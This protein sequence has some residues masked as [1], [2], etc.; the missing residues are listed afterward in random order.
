M[1]LNTCSMNECW[2]EQMNDAEKMPCSQDK[3]V[4]ERASR[5]GHKVDVCF[6]LCR[7]MKGPVLRVLRR[8]APSDTSKINWRTKWSKSTSLAGMQPSLGCRKW[9]ASVLTPCWWHMVLYDSRTVLVSNMVSIPP[10]LKHLPLP[11]PRH[12]STEEVQRGGLI[13]GMLSM[14][15]ALSSIHSHEKQIDEQTA[16]NVPIQL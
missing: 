7:T 1:L 5:K 4:L 15:K 10:Y 6:C 13:E 3:T 11:Q 16:T 14:F 2:R 12:P 8:D 9:L